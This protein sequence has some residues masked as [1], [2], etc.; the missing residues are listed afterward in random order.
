MDANL[1]NQTGLSA[2]IN[3]L[4]KQKEELTLIYHKA[5]EKGEKLTE[6]R[7]LYLSLKEIDKKL[8]D[9]LRVCF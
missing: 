2:L 9:L 6:V 5:I 8:N 7:T 4:Q 3:G 1:T